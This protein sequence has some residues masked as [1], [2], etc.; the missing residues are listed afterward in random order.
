[1]ISRT[2][3]LIASLS[4]DLAASKPRIAQAVLIT[5]EVGFCTHTPCSHAC[6]FGSAL[7][8]LI[9]KKVPE[10]FHPNPHPP[11]VWT[12]ENRTLSSPLSYSDSSR[13]HWLETREQTLSHM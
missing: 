5:K 13:R 4:G 9:K 2:A 12:L 10:S 3:L 8:H 1:M 6:K 11:S 7:S